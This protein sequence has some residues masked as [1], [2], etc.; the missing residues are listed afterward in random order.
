MALTAE[1]TADS[2]E[3]C[4]KVIFASSNEAVASVSATGKVKA[5]ATGAA[6][7]TARSCNGLEARCEITVVSTGD[8][9]KASFAWETASIVAG[10]SA[11]LNLRLNKAAI[12]RGYTVTSSAP[13]ALSVVG[14]RIVAKTATA[15]NVTLTLVVNAAD[16][17]EAI[18]PALCTVRVLDSIAP[19][20]SASDLELEA[21]DEATPEKSVGELFLSGVPAD[22]IGVCTLKVSDE[23]IIQYDRDAGTVRAQ[24]QLGVATITLKTFAGEIS[25][26][27][28]VVSPVKY[29]AV[30][31][32]EYNNS[33][34]TASNL[35]FAA[36]N[37]AGIRTALANS[38]VD[39][40]RYEITSYPNNPSEAQ[41]R[42]GIANAFVDADANDVS[43]VYIVSHGYNDVARG[44]YHFGTPNWSKND[45]ST[46]VTSA[47]LFSWLSAINGNVV[48]VLDS[49]KSGAFVD[50]CKSKLAAAGNI[51]VMTA[52]I[53]T[54]NAS[55]YVGRTERDQIEF[56][57][58]SFCKGLGYDLQF[59]TLVAMAADANGDGSVTVQEA[60]SFAKSE[61]TAQ[62][63]AK[64]STFDASSKYGIKV[65]GCY[66]SAL[67]KSWGGQTPVIYVP[68]GMK[69]LV[70]YSR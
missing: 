43:V 17:E 34:Q 11:A 59:S 55:Y 24:D 26:T 33:S 2:A 52:Q 69:N 23:A 13:E 60:I 3:Y 67:F 50:D 48:L 8:A 53:G 6:T 18:E 68:D 49:C 65:P 16:G 64:K 36:K 29:R 42:S 70:L 12:E 57:T 7:I 46:Y 40:E 58:Y 51:A 25:C 66:T 9:S 1:L 44:G 45:P 30:I 28:T 61:T 5:L 14:N 41:I 4:D 56:M 21:Y 15:E 27:V 37:V 54:K 20:F 62:V 38:Y 19:A 32:G 22:L 63:N 31:F 35:P 10:D 47:E 39:G